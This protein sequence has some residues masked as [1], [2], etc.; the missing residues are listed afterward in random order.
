[1]LEAFL[2]PLHP[3]DHLPSPPSAERIFCCLKGFSF[4]G[5]FER[6]EQ[7]LWKGFFPSA[8][9]C[10]PAPSFGSIRSGR[11]APSGRTAV[12]TA[13]DL[14]LLLGAPTGTAAQA[15]QKHVEVRVTSPVTG[16]ERRTRRRADT[17]RW[18]DGMET[19]T[20]ASEH[21]KATTFG[22]DKPSESLRKQPLA[23]RPFGLTTVT[24]FSKT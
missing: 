24:L 7:T 1:M 2:R 12:G 19:Q 14:Y 3:S 5:P 6:W 17:D 23:Q 11:T 16:S 21:L 22:D 8:A 9:I 4:S 20:S 18:A 10:C 15:E 13:A